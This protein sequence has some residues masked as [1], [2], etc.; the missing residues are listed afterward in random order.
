VAPGYSTRSTYTNTGLPNAAEPPLMALMW[1]DLYP[2]YSNGVWHYHDAAN[3]RFIIQYDSM[4]T[5]ANRT[6]FDWFQVVIYDTTMAGPD[7]NSVFVYQYL[8]ANNFGSA[9]VGEQNPDGDIAIQDLYNGSYHRAA[10]PIEAGRA[11]K[12]TT[13][14]PMAI[15]G[16]GQPAAAM[17][18]AVRVVGNP[19]RGHA[20]FAVH[21]ARPGPARLA[22]YD[23]S[24]RLVRSLV[25]SGN[26]ALEP[27]RYDVTWDGRDRSG[28][29][30]ARGVY[31]VRLD[32]GSE[33]VGRKLVLLD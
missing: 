31:L 23:A 14:D 24:G 8:T 19:S 12:F 6:V 22:V 33:S 1:D 3:H 5:Y 18:G 20:R 7:G 17:A 2:P 27:G 9:T 32:T 15:A 16:G 11:I 4:P 26:R 30:T 21:I 10:L 28:A 25:D 13:A 29:K